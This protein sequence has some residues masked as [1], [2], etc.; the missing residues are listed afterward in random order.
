MIIL[1]NY[2]SLKEIKKAA[3]EKVAADAADDGELT[4]DSKVSR[5]R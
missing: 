4:E 5:M 3:E 1:K 2:K